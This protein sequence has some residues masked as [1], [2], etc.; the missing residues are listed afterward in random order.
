MEHTCNRFKL[1]LYWDEVRLNENFLGICATTS[2]C[3]GAAL[4]NCFGFID[5]TVRPIC[6]PNLHQ[7][8]VYNGHKFVLALQDDATEF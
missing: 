3:K 1:L 4:D 6:Q 5:G 8:E 2:H 7:K